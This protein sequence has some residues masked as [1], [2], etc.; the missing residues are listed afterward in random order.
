MSK[1]LTLRLD[2]PVYQLFKTVAERENR[3]ISNFIET[4]AMRFVQEYETVNEFEMAEIRGNIELNRSLKR[5]HLDAKKRRGAF[6]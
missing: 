5:G 3:P 1:T 6:I 4:A 2:E